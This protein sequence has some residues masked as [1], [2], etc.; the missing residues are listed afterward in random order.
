M[1]V[2]STKGAPTTDTYKDVTI[3]DLG[4]S[5]AFLKNHRISV[6]V[7]NVLDQSTTEWQQIESKGKVSYANLYSDLVDGRNLWVSY[8]YSF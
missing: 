7:N 8:N 6:A 1:A 4:A 2:V 5:Y 3:V